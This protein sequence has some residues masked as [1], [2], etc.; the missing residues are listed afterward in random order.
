MQ[1]IKSSPCLQFPGTK[2][3]GDMTLEVYGIGNIKLWRKRQVASFADII[4][5]SQLTRKPTLH[6]TKTSCLL[7]QWWDDCGIN[8]MGG[9]QRHRENKNANH[10]DTYRNPRVF[11]YLSSPQL[12]NSMEQSLSWEAKNSSDSQETPR[13]LWNPKFQ[14]RGYKGP[15]MP[16]P[17][18]TFRNKLHLSYSEL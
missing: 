9:T 5:W 13:L 6:P 16:G 1:K 4:S 18:V 17:C 3:R 12:T 8:K 10:G 14:Y 15:P 7:R 2:H 11:P